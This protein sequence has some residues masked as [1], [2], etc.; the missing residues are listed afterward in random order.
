MALIV[1]AM[2]ELHCQA[3]MGEQC[4]QTASPFWLMDQICECVNLVEQIILDCNYA[5]HSSHEQIDTV[6]IHKHSRHIIGATHVAI[7]PKAERPTKFA[8]PRRAESGQRDGGQGEVDAI[9]RPRRLLRLVAPGAGSQVAALVETE[10]RPPLRRRRRKRGSSRSAATGG[11][12]SAPAADS[13]STREGW[14]WG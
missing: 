2:A 13:H 11:H 9:V 14:G 6:C 4:E 3:N 5:Y 10:Q 7:I 8:P 12:A 1:M